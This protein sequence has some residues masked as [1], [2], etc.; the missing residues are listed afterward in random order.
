[1]YRLFYLFSFDVCIIDE[2]AQALEAACWIPLIKAR[3]C[4]L[5]G[6][7]L[8]LPPTVL[9]EAAAKKGLS[10][11]L[12]ERLQGLFG[13][14]SVGRMLTVQ[15]RMNEGIMKWSSDALYGG[16]LTGENL[17]NKKFV[18]FCK[19]ANYAL[20]FFLSPLLYS[21]SDFLPF[22]FVAQQ[23]TPLSPSTAFRTSESPSPPPPSP[24]FFS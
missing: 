10:V 19:I 22:F 24:C 11:T 15:Y 16:R 1:M 23:P 8:Q 18:C 14:E 3:R 9:S 4:V 6:D 12:F 21:T 20:S 2:A 17:S 13:G 7:H 5:A